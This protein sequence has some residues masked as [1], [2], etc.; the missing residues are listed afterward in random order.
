MGISFAEPERLKEIFDGENREEWQKTSH[1]IRSIGLKEDDTVADL[2]AGTGY[3][4]NI[5]SQ[6]LCK[7]KVYSIDCEPNMVAYMRERFSDEQFAHVQ[8]IQSQ[9]DNPCIPTDVNW[10]FVANTYRFIHHRDAFLQKMR[11]QT[12]PGTTFVFVDFKG[13]NARVSPQMAIDEVKNA[14]FE[15]LH[16]DTEGCPDHYILTFI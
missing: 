10:V 1:I 4:S 6:I 15:I 5:F 2:G 16:L 8:V 7:G 14:G 3:F 12:N 11:E 9:P 13:V